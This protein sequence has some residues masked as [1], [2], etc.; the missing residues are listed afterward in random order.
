MVVGAALGIPL[1]AALPA[2]AQAALAIHPTRTDDP[3][4]GGMTCSFLPANNTDCSLR[5]ALALAGDGTIVS[6]AP[7]APGG[8]YTVQSTPLTI[9]HNITLA[10]VGAR[11]TKIE[12]TGAAGVLEI[13]SGV[14]GATVEDLTVTGG[15]SQDGGG[16]LNLG[17]LTLRDSAVTGNVA[18]A[19][20]SPGAGGG[21]YSTTTLTV[22]GSAVTGNQAAG[23]I[24][25][26]QSGLGGG[27][28]IGGTTTI[29]NSTIS[30]N[31]AGPTPS[32]GTGDGGGI[33]MG[34]GS[35]T[36]SLS[37]VTLASNTAI[38]SAGNLYLFSGAA[39]AKD[40]IIGLGTASDSGT[41]NCNGAVVSS[42]GYNLEDRN[43]CG[44]AGTGDQTNTDPLLGALQNNGGPTDT[45]GLSLDSP[46]VDHGNPAGCT[47]ASNALLSVDQRRL[48]RPQG[49]ACDVGAY[50]LQPL[51]PAASG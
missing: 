36:L 35:P 23:N 50:E 30:G 1:S 29:V 39:S 42:L 44:L 34:G 13:G 18:A 24:L 20:P 31:A 43:Q 33:Y 21:I 3:S 6:L 4:S 25:T 41:Q 51:A 45:Q 7:P 19:G 27:I 8:P 10:G 26:L 2:A 49:L 16:I 46:A 11:T 38:G 15:H 37:N 5:N 14:T 17:G 48:T 12:Q 22:I 28:F 32:V 40:T 47:D 9:S